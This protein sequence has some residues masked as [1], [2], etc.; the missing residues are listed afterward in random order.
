MRSFLLFALLWPVCCTLRAAAPT[1]PNVVILLVD[2]LGWGDVSCLNHGAV[3]TPNID[4]IAAAGVKF[5]SGYVTAP[6]CGP[7]RAAFFSGRYAQRFGFVDNSGGIP[8][9]QTLLP[10]VI[11]AA[12]APKQ[13]ETLGPFVPITQ[14]F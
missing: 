2:D 11:S 5:T 1:R 13:F 12:R 14:E 3:K 6:L 7:S 4:R 10:G 8:T 9:T